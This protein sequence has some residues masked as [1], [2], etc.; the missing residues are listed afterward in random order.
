[1]FQVLPSPDSIG[2]HAV[3]N[4]VFAGLDELSPQNLNSLVGDESLEVRLVPEFVSPFK[5]SV[6]DL[7]LLYGVE[8]VL[9]EKLGM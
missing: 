1:M 5:E 8:D 6:Q 2:F 7:V 3:E 9:G 4:F